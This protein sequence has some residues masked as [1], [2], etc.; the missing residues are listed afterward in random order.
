MNIDELTEA[1][2]RALQGI[3]SCP[4][5]CKCCTEH[6]KELREALALFMKR[7]QQCE[8]CEE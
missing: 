8:A 5:G 7:W 4:G 1:L 3:S 2:Y 6:D